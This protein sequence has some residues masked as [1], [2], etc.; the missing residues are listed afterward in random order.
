MAP[1]YFVKET[2]LDNIWTAFECAK[3]EG[4][5]VEFDYHNTTFTNLKGLKIKEDFDYRKE[6]LRRL[7]KE[8]QNLFYSGGSDSHTI[9]TLSEQLDLDWQSLVTVV[10]APTYDG[11]A[12]KEYM[13]G[14]QYA[15][16]RKHNIEVWNH[17]IHHWEKVYGD[18][19]FMYKNGG[20]INLRADYVHFAENFDSTKNYVTGQEKPNLLYHDS[21]WYTWYDSRTYSAYGGLHNVK[22]FFISPEMPEIYFQECRRLRNHYVA[23]K[24]TPINGTV[25]GKNQELDRTVLFDNPK[26]QNDMLVNE[27]NSLALAQLWQMGRSDVIFNWLSIVE[28]H[29]KKHDYQVKWNQYYG[30]TPL[31]CWLVDIDSLESIDTAEFGKMLA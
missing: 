8:E 9:L 30:H 22:H 24:G 19:Q 23:T 12:N 17:D 6:Y 18:P 25:I 3:N 16:K 4:S 21:H 7:F 27:K 31:L 14:I 26:V 5:H 2:K 1:G 13:P 11:Q 15:T 28:A 10:S 29:K 20:E